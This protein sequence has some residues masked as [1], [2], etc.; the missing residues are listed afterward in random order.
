[1][2]HGFIFCSSHTERPPSEHCPVG[3][4]CTILALIRGSASLSGIL[5][6]Y[7]IKPGRSSLCRVGLRR[8]GLPWEAERLMAEGIAPCVHPGIPAWSAS[9]PSGLLCSQ[10]SQPLRA[11]RQHSALSVAQA[12]VPFCTLCPM[13]RYS[14][15]RYCMPSLPDRSERDRSLPS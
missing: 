10:C 6:L 2:L 5:V 13:L 3:S 14:L 8:G 7:R 4:T 12:G 15:R 9:S 1:M 11:R